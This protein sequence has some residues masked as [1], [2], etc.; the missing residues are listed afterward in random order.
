[1]KPPSAPQQQGPSKKNICKQKHFSNNK[2]HP[3]APHFN[4]R[5]RYLIQ[6]E[7]AAALDL[8][9]QRMAVRVDARRLLENELVLQLACVCVRVCVSESVYERGK[10]E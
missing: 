4:S 6:R 10:A 8:V 7:V 9:P 5:P 2:I 1:M 3:S